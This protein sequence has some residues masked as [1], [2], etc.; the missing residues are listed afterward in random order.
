MKQILICKG[1]AVTEDVPAPEVGPRHVLVRTAHSCVSVG[2][3][4][5]GVRLSGMPLYKR[6]LKHPENV[7]LAWRMMRE[8]GARRTVNAIR[9]MQAAGDAVG[10][11]AA[12][13]ILEV[14]AEVEG[15]APGDR[16]ACA[17]AGV[18]NHAEVIN[19]PVNL[20][21]PIP[22]GLD[23]AAACTVAL[24]SI[25]M[26][27]VRRLA[28]QLGETVAVI[29]LG[30]LGQLTAQMLRLS[31]CRVIG[32]DLDPARVD[33]ARTL[34]LAHAAP[35]DP[36]EFTAS[37]LRLSDGYGADAVVICAAA[38][39][40][41]IVSQA[42]HA[43]RK[44][45]RVV[46]VG[47]VGLGLKRADFYAK[48]ID[49]LI[50]SS[51]GP[52]RYDPVYEAGGC[53][54]PFPYVRWTEGR[55]MQEYLRLLATSAIVLDPL[56][57]GIYEAERAAEAYA[58]LAGDGD[59]PLLAVLAYPERSGE[60]LSRTTVLRTAHPAKGRIGVA[61]C[62]AG[63]FAQGMHLPN[64]M[65]LHKQFELR[66]IMSRTGATAKAAATRY[67]AATATTDYAQVLADPDVRLVML[68]TRHDLHADMVLAALQAGKNVFVEKPLCLTRPQLLA[69]EAFYAGNPHGP[70][71]MTGYNRRFSPAMVRLRELLARRSTPIMASY[72]MNAGF[73]PPEHWVHGPEGGGRNIGEACH[74][75]DLFV[76]LC[77]AEITSLSA[78]AIRPPGR[79]W[80]RDDNFTATL[81]FKDGSV[82][83]LTYTAL[84][85][86]EFPKETMDVF[87]DQM[88]LSL[89]DY[90]R[91]DV[92]GSRAKGWSAGT[93]DKG[94]LAQLRLL[95]DC[96]LGGTPW[97]I[98]LEEQLA[99]AQAALDVQSLLPD[100]Q[101]APDNS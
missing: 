46:L 52:G 50:S 89:G 28:P 3:E 1:Q 59:K 5:A 68:C 18:A 11:S 22:D 92:H 96:L 26:Q 69:I 85:S 97:P 56:A 25:A 100:P 47:D 72:R 95:G 36:E 82:C 94:H 62:G 83:N 6:A 93:V 51:Y 64:L 29:G 38:A 8:E 53:D 37:V 33:L 65:K 19:V 7:A 14:G 99:S 30:L 34:G 91:L 42:F 76:S 77:G 86:R 101:T 21:T 2:T 61:V 32:T 90:R 12:G 57:S 24:G 10:Y 49:F 27:G 17:G 35:A 79:Q 13:T 54:Y 31:G 16:V 39:T 15:F 73:L 81:S 60:V 78:A 80:R 88:V 41:A 4:A 58:S 98:P 44:K 40:D 87:C 43:C 84:G 70:L 55:N 71:M 67:E 20:T 74:I 75:Y 48:E 63:A 23:T 66:S 45:G 9:G